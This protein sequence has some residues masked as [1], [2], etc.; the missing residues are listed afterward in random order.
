[1]S[2]EKSSA[3]YVFFGVNSG[4]IRYEQRKPYVF[5]WGINGKMWENYVDNVDNLVYNSILA[6]KRGEELWM[7]ISWIMW[8]TWISCESNIVF[9]QFDRFTIILLLCRL[10]NKEI[11]FL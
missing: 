3:F 9:V 11:N 4:F 1:M 10:C 5:P 2:A 7:Q 6:E 8:I